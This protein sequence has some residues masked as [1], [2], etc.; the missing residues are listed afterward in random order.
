MENGPNCPVNGIKID[1]T[2]VRLI[3]AQVVVLS[4]TAAILP[5]PAVSIFLVTDFGLRAFGFG[6]YSI[7]K[8][9]AK[10][11]KS[12]LKLPGKMTDEAS[13][14]FAAKIGFTVMILLAAAQFVNWTFVS[15][16]LSGMIIVFATLESVMGVCIGCMAYNTIYRVRR[17]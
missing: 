6:Q 9:V 1:E 2:V 13:K 14:R 12:S 3:A 4:G 10:G 8:S 5:A 16:S 7:L 17:V 15:L 11:I